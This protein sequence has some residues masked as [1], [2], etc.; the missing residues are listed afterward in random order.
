MAPMPAAPPAPGTRTQ[1][2][3]GRSRAGVSAAIRVRGIGHPR[4]DVNE[5]IG[6]GG[7]GQAL[8]QEAPLIDQGAVQFILFGITVIIIFIALWITIAK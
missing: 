5:A 7:S 1:A 4:G 8:A 3:A 6:K 2:G